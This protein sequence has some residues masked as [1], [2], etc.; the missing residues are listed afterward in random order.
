[1]RA[2]TLSVIIA[3]T[4]ITPVLA[5][6]L[7]DE[8]G[9]SPGQKNSTSQQESITNPGGFGKSPDM[10]AI[11]PNR[12]GSTDLDCRQQKDIRTERSAKATN[13]MDCVR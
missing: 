4:V 6:S 2:R 10:K 5:E 12:T 1:M 3:I 11:D 7:P 8:A 9:P 13:N